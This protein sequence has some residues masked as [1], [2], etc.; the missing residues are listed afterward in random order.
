M[1]AI[2]SP[3]IQDVGALS[4]FPGVGLF[5]NDGTTLRRYNAGWTE[6]THQGV[7]S[8]HEFSEYNAT[9]NVLVY[10]GGNSSPYKKIN[11]S[12]V[13]TNLNAPSFTLGGAATMG[14]AQSHPTA[15]KLICHDPNGG[16]WISYDISGSGSSASISKVGGNG[17]SIATGAP[18]LRTGVDESAIG[19]TVPQYGVIVYIQWVSGAAADVWVYKPA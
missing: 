5:Y 10:G 6:I 1:P 2:P 3:S 19:I 7:D 11:S 8:Y 9:A 14:L 16:S 15:A 4:W 17:S 12:L 13:I 18:N